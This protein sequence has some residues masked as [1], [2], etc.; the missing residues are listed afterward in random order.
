MNHSKSYHKTSR[1]E[2]IGVSVI[3]L[4]GIAMTIIS[5]QKWCDPIIDFGH[6]LYI[7]WALYNGK[8]LYKDIIMVFYG[9]LPYY[10]NAL[11]FKAFGTHLNVIVYFNLLLILV[12]TCIIYKIIHTT[13]NSLCAFFS[14]LSFIVLF[15]FQRHQI[16]GNFN[17]VTPYAHAA[18]HAMILSLAAI[19]F[20]SCYLNSKKPIFAYGCWLTVGLVLLTKTEIF[21]G[22]FSSMFVTWGWILQAERPSPKLLSLRLITCLALLIAP[23][24]LFVLFFSPGLS[25]YEAFS[26]II[27]P[28][29]LGLHKD[30]SLNPFL[31]RVM[32][33]EAPLSNFYDM[34]SW[35][36]IYIS[37]ALILLITNHFLSNSKRISQ[38]KIASNLIALLT[39][40]P[41]IYKTIQ[42]KL[43]YL[44]YF[45]PLPIVVMVYSV[46]ITFKLCKEPRHGVT[47]NQRVMCLSFALFSFVLLFRKIL[48]VDLVHYSFFLVLPG[49]L[50][51]L[52][53]ILHDFPLLMR[54]ISNSA[55]IGSMLVIII[56]TCMIYSH[57]TCSLT[58]YSLVDSPIR[59]KQG[60]IKTFDLRNE[61]IGGIIED[62][63][64][65]I[66]GFVKPSETFTV[67][68]EGLMFNYLTQRESP[69]PYTA[70]IPPLLIEFGDSILESFRKEPPDFVLLVERPTIEYGLKYFG[71]DYGTEIFHWIKENYSEICQIGKKPLSGQGFGIIIMKRMSSQALQQNAIKPLAD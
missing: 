10:I 50:M 53:I 8:Y 6:E 63:L 58:L 39:I 66:G 47:W 29:A 26:H 51:L 19:L 2:A 24:F 43:P 61:N 20:V 44:E 60:V 22:I 13:S 54:K 23:L 69:S 15:A 35:L 45:R 18:T 4:V 36:S 41:F 55:Q 70:F 27:Y 42:S 65:Q 32:G 11:L 12:T 56:V 7:P 33:I 40:A 68:P 5:W 46:Y 21:V 31:T 48:N 28:Y 71:K 38:Y 67:F 62:A 1:L 64:S 59:S 3:A 30:F 14:S 37:V 9:P 49:F 52:V 16:W 25:P 17:F 57:F 34:V